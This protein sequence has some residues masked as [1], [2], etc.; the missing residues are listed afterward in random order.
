MIAHITTPLFFA[1]TDK[2][3][4][5]ESK[6]YFWASSQVESIQSIGNYMMVVDLG[7]IRLIVI[8]VGPLA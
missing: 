6:L 1:T 4:S 2:G 7:H 5:S 8:G 3:V